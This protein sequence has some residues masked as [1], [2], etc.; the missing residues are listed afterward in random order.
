MNSMKAGKLLEIIIGL[1]ETSDYLGIRAL[2]DQHS[3]K[4]S[5]R[6]AYAGVWV[7][8]EK[9][10][11]ISR[12][13]IGPRPRLFFEFHWDIGEPLGTVKPFALIEKCPL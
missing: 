7:K 9:A 5:A 11:L 13:T 4:I 12:Y 6:N 2:K 1:R 3:Y 10:F 8:R